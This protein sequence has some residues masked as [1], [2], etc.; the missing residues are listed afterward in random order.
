V[1]PM[2]YIAAAAFVIYFSIFYVREYLT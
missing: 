1:S 2:M